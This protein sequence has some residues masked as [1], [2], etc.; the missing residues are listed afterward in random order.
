MVKKDRT[1]KLQGYIAGQAEAWNAIAEGWHASIP[2]MRAWFARATGLMLDLARIDVGN[3]VLDLPIHMASAEECVRYLQA[4][5]PGLDK[6]IS[7]LS[8]TERKQVWGEVHQAL[9]VYERAQG[10]EV[11]NKVI[12]AAGS[13]G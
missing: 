8:P 7:P 11:M 6:L 9:T 4:S 5:S 13:A 12:V 10:F 2:M 3:R 1:S